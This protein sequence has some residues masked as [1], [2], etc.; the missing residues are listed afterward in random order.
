MYLGG[1]IL[2]DCF[3]G[4][5]R[6]AETYMLKADR[7]ANIGEN[8][9]FF[10]LIGYFMGDG[11]TV[12]GLYVDE[13]ENKY[14]AGL[15]GNFTNGTISNLI[16]KDAYVKTEADTDNNG[17][18]FDSAGIIVGGAVEGYG[19]SITITGCSASGTVES[20]SAITGGLIGYFS[21]ANITDCT[22]S[23][24][25]KGASNAGGFVGRGLLGSVSRCVAEGDVS[26]SWC[27]GGFAGIA[28]YETKIEKCASYGDV[29]QATGMSADSSAL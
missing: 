5:I 23:T 19:C 3:V 18:V 25:V 1:K 28:F 21:Y 15:F 22:A 6:V 27:V 29:L 16:V 4:G 10:A 12:T 8:G 9:R 24:T 20:G 26:G 13:S 17:E 7:S 14:T 11:K 2:D